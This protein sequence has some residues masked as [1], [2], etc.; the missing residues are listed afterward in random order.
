MVDL[1]LSSL[2]SALFGA[3]IALG[4]S[5]I[6]QKR[7]RDA[8]LREYSQ[9]DPGGWQAWQRG[10][11]DIRDWATSIQGA[12][13]SG[14]SREMQFS[15]I[16]IPGPR[17]L[18]YLIRTERVPPE[19][20]QRS[21][22]LSDYCALLCDLLT[23]VLAADLRDLRTLPPTPVADMLE[24]GYIEPAAIQ[25]AQAIADMAAELA[26]PVAAR[27]S[28]QREIAEAFAPRRLEP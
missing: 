14:M 7:V 10:F 3:L 20:L 9:H 22:I 8:R 21:L 18:D 24:E 4:L 15:F 2:V 26:D 16:R 6:V 25:L 11:Y 17:Y 5:S 23:Q 27:R 19:Y 1:L 12:L 13:Q 28:Q